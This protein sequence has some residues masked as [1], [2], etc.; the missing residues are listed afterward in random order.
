MRAYR[1]QLSWYLASASYWFSSSF[2]WFLALMILPNKVSAIVPQGEQNGAWGMVIVFGAVEATIGPALAGYLSDRLRTRKIGR[3]PFLI[4]GAVL[5]AIALGL[6]SQADTLPTL[7][8]AYLLLQISDDVSTGPYA[9]L[10]PDIVPHEHRGYA[11]GIRGALDQGA[12][13]VGAVVAFMFSRDHTLMLGIVAVVNLGCAFLVAATVQETFDRLPTA[14][15][16]VSSWFTP[17][18]DHDF[19]IMFLSQ[20]LSS[21]G[22]YMIYFYSQTFLM[23]VIGI[24]PK[25]SLKY[26]AIIAVVLSLTAAIASIYSGRLADKIGR[27]KVIVTAGWIMF[28]MLMPFALVKSF[29]AI[30]VLAALFGLGFGPF[31]ASI[32]ALTS[33][34]VGESEEVAKDMGIWQSA[35]VFPQLLSGVIGIG[36][37]YVNRY[38][39]GLGYSMSF[40]VAAFIFLAGALV[41]S[42]IKRVE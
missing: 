7:I 39:K 32:W 40:F 29:P 37:D 41:V 8:V 2:K 34:V 23:D 36:I 20:L 27:K 42:S 33:D 35:T 15:A 6:L 21:L 13:I 24:D 5:T 38:Q 17:W 1:H 3:V 19:R 12:R 16:K 25:D 10:I 18:K 4:V 30:V 28:C 26:F 9:A 31:S 11:S 14:K 22:F